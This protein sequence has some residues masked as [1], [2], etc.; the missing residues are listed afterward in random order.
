MQRKHA[1]VTRISGYWEKK[2]KLQDLQKQED[3]ST[4]PETKRALQYDRSCRRGTEV[5]V[6]VR[7]GSRPQ[8]PCLAREAKKGCATEVVFQ[9]RGQIDM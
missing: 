5:E 7:R 2:K 6:S 1:S 9:Q 3:A 8:A 4:D